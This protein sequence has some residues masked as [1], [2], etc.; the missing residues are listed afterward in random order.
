MTPS[1]TLTAKPSSS[2]PVL[3]LPQLRQRKSIL[4]ATAALEHVLVVWPVVSFTDDVR[5]SELEL[6]RQGGGT[7]P[8]DAGSVVAGA[9]VL[10]AHDVDFVVWGGGAANA[11]ELFVVC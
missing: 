7:G 6:G 5:G 3:L 9:G 10:A 1:P 2:L 8:F 4:D 11:F